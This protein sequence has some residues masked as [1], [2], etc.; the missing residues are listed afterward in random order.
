MN[1]GDPIVFSPDCWVHGLGS[2]TLLAKASQVKGTV[3]FV[4]PKGRYNVA[5][6]EVGGRTIREAY[7]I[8]P[9]N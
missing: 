5:Q 7:Q 4:H 2:E 6:G 1:V 9:R 8:I 3:I